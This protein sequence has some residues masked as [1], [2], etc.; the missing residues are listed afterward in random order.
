LQTQELQIIKEK[1]DNNL[2]HSKFEIQKLTKEKEDLIHQF[3]EDKNQNQT[4]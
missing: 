2:T 1:V 4:L 3:T